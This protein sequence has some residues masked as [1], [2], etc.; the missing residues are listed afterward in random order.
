MTRPE[1]NHRRIGS[2]APLCAAALLAGCAQTP[3]VID[4]AADAEITVDGRYEDWGGRFTRIDGSRSVGLGIANDR[5]DLYLCLVTRDLGVQTLLRRGGFTVW[6]DPEGGQR[7]RIGVRV[8]PVE[9]EVETAVTPRVE[10]VRDGAEYG[11][12]LADPTPE[13]PVDVKTAR[14][15]DVVV[16]EFRLTFEGSLMGGEEGDMRARL[17]RSGPLGVG[18]VTD[19]LTAPPDGPRGGERPQTIEPLAAWVVTTLSTRAGPSGGG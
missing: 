2:F 8:A 10:I 14:S 18:V 11:Y 16:Y 19:P 12:Q 6:L 15:A 3:L 13:G 7:K 1:T 4:A 9:G 5:A 17:T